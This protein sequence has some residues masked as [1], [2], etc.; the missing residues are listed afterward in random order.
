VTISIPDHGTRA[1]AG[2]G[3]PSVAG[4]VVD[5]RVLF[6]R[7]CRSRVDFG[8]RQASV[9]SVSVQYCCTHTRRR[10]WTFGKWRNRGGASA[11]YTAFKIAIPSGPICRV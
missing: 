5:L 6:R 7:L 11:A 4:A 9:P 8:P 2:S 1:E 10:I 3:R